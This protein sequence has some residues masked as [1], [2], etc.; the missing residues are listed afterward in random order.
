MESQLND[1]IIDTKGKRMKKAQLV[2]QQVNS[3]QVC[4]LLTTGI[5]Q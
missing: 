5:Y 4:A 2:Q 1:H 3:N